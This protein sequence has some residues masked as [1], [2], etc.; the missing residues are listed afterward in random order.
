MLALF[1]VVAVVA[2]DTSE[3]NPVPPPST[4]EPPPEPTPEP[5]ELPEIYVE[6]S[7]TPNV[8]SDG[9]VSFEI[10][11]N[12]PD[13]MELM[14]TLSGGGDFN[15]QAKIKFSNGIATSDTFS[16]QGDPLEGNFTL[17][18]SSAYASLS[19]DNV[20]AIIGINGEAMIGQNVKIDE[21]GDHF[22]KA[23]FYFEF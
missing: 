2:C 9:K 22:I 1:M 6:I 23:E 15:A 16:N 11:S 13:D 7:V 8:G 10:K 17:R 21:F 5:E 14:L 12:L 3:Q 20:K 19:P 18:I 4:P